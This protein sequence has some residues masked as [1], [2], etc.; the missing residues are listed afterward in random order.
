MHE[1]IMDFIFHSQEQDKKK[2]FKMNN[3]IH[4]SNIILSG[5]SYIS[6][7]KFE[8]TESCVI[9]FIV[10]YELAFFYRF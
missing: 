8:L 6:I 10:T 5:N 9:K 1:P 2:P 4:I 7:D 3:S